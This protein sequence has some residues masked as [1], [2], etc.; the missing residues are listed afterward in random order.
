VPVALAKLREHFAGIERVGP[1]RYARFFLGVTEDD[2]GRDRL[3][4]DA[5]AVL[6][7]FLHEWEIAGLP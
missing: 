7:L 2:D 6:Q 4:R 1:S 5:H 3:R